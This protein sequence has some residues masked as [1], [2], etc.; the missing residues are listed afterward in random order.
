MV[1]LE[2]ESCFCKMQRNVKVLTLPEKLSQRPRRY[3]DTCL[4]LLVG[5]QAKGKSSKE[6][7]CKSGFAAFVPL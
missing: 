4:R 3:R 2:G 7:P 6:C 5:R 1:M